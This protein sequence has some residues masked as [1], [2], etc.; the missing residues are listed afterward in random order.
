MGSP[1]YRTKAKPRLTRA[2][3]L[4][5]AC[6]KMLKNSD[7]PFQ[8][9]RSLRARLTVSPP[10]FMWLNFYPCE[11]NTPLSLRRAL[12]QEF[13]VYDDVYGELGL[14]AALSSTM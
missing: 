1:K 9:T 5:D 3:P 8:E 13:S 2:S 10:E 11:T 12:R 4:L 7:L 14:S 6:V